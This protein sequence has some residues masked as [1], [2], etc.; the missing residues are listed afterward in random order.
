MEGVR[1][2][3]VRVGGRSGEVGPRRDLEIGIHAVRGGDV[4]GE[5]TVWF[6]AEGERVGLTHAA[7]S[8]RTFANGAVA[9]ARW[10]VTR[11]PGRYS[12]LDV[13]GMTG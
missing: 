5:H 9:A 4:V 7:S 12:L 6:L 13:L 1:T 10:I 2:G 11:P 3:L 8:Q